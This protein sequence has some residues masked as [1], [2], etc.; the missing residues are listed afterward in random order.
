MLLQV[1]LST[2]LSVLDGD[3]HRLGTT[4]GEGR[5]IALAVVQLAIQR[6]AQ[7][8]RQFTGGAAHRHLR[9]KRHISAQHI[10]DR[11]NELWIVVT[12]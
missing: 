6:I 2:V 10:A 5:D 12:E 11:I 1:L 9:I 4:V 7:L 3:F 8:M